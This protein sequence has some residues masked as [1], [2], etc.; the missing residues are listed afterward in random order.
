LALQRFAHLT[1]VMDL[2]LA[3]ASLALATGWDD[4]APPGG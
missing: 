3:W 4:L 1:A 2:N